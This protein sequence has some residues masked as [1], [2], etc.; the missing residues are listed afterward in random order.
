[1]DEHCHIRSSC[2]DLPRKGKGKDIHQVGLLNGTLQQV[3]VDRMGV[4]GLVFSVQKD[5]PLW[6]EAPCMK[7]EREVMSTG[8]RE[9]NWRYPTDWCHT[10]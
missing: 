4:L 9:P 8:R 6:A 10:E 3:M 5:D 1:M 7:S 2:L